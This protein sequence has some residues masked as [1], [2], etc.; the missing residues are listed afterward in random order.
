MEITEKQFTVAHSLA[1]AYGHEWAGLPARY[2]W[3]VFWRA[4]IAAG[5]D[6][7]GDD[8]EVE[9]PQEAILTGPQEAILTGLAAVARV[10]ADAMPSHAVGGITGPSI[11]DTGAIAHTT[12]TG[13]LRWEVGTEET[14]LTVFRPH[15]GYTDGA[16][17][18]HAVVEHGGRLVTAGGPDLEGDGAPVVTCHERHVAALLDAAM[19]T[20]AHCDWA[21]EPDADGN[22]RRRSD[23]LHDGIR[24]ALA[25]LYE[26]EPGYL[27]V[28]YEPA[29]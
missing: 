8:V 26:P 18:C 13:R 20:V 22:E 25:G 10:V 16:P 24:A 2:A 15:E 19:A 27:G 29:A 1:N 4:S 3:A 21:A 11:D 14:V 5:A 6:S 17:A 23:V 9:G 7:I 28:P 12:G